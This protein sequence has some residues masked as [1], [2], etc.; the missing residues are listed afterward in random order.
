MSERTDR[1]AAMTPDEHLALSFELAS[2]ARA[3]MAGG[4]N[5]RMEGLTLALLH[6]QWAT[7]KS[8]AGSVAG[9]VR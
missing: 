1:L 2:T 3:S 7:A 9:R 4:P 8:V 6:A 5:A